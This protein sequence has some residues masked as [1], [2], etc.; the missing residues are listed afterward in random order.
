MMIMIL[1]LYPA[2]CGCGIRGVTYPLLHP[3]ITAPAA[4]TLPGDA[5]TVAVQGILSP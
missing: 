2:A 4:P 5:D 3:E 1:R